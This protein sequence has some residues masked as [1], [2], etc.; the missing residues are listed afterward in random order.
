[1]TCPEY[2]PE[3]GGGGDQQMQTILSEKHFDTI[4]AI[5]RGGDGMVFCC[6]AVHLE[7]LATSLT[8]LMK[9]FEQE[10]RQAGKEDTAYQQAMK[11]VSG[12]TQKTQGEEEILQLEDGLF[13]KARMYRHKGRQAT[14]RCY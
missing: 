6:S 11:D 13:V 4:S 9:G 5:S 1:V 7:Y 3:K 14:Q 8:K 2:R 10:I 12:S